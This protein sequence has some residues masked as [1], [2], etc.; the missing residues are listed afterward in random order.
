MLFIDSIPYKLGST[1]EAISIDLQLVKHFTENLSLYR[2]YRSSEIYLF[3]KMFESVCYLWFH[4]N[5]LDIVD[6]VFHKSHYVFI[7]D[8]INEELP[9]EYNLRQDPNINE[10]RP[11][12]YFNKTAISLVELKREYFKLQVSSIPSMPLIKTD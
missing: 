4:N 11:Y 6:Y 10:V 1:F 2:S 7:K 5:T 8:S 3:G 9:L 12:T